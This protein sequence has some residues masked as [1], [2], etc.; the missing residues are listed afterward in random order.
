MPTLDHQVSAVSSTIARWTSTIVVGILFCTQ[1]SSSQLTVQLPDDRWV[2][3]YYPILDG[4][5]ACA[6]LPELYSSTLSVPSRR[7]RIWLPSYSIPAAM[8]DLRLTDGTVQ[9]TW[10]WWW[11]TNDA[12]LVRSVRRLVR[13]EY[14]CST[15]VRC[16]GYEY[17]VQNF[18][19]PPQWS[20]MVAALELNDVWTLPDESTMPKT[21][22][23]IFDGTSIIVEART[24]QT[25]R[26]YYY[27]EPADRPWPEE[28]KAAAMMD[29][30]YSLYRVS[31][32]KQ[33]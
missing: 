15:I 11:E 7:L 24:D 18:R 3:I 21:N 5:A 1:A 12:K 29:A 9:G 31:T 4:V 27:H 14:N 16:E 26:S 28:K 30:I 17:C 23:I 33:K 20:P 8:V 13:H 6:N 2:E 32:G 22:I 10:Y 19:S 25:Y